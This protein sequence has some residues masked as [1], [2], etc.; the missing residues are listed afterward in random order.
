[1]GVHSWGSGPCDC[2]MVSSSRI[3]P[4]ENEDVGVIS[5]H[6]APG[7]SPVTW[8]VVPSCCRVKEEY[9]VIPALKEVP[10]SWGLWMEGRDGGQLCG[11]AGVAGSGA[12]S[13]C[14]LAGAPHLLPCR[15]ESLKIV[16]I[17][18]VVP[19]RGRYQE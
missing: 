1:M 14:A 12:A 16:K 18:R 6:V 2:E 4:L 9:G 7:P 5:V 17:N 3:L 11:E 15:S 10:V 13:L 19:V 8:A